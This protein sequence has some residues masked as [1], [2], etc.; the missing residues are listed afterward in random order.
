MS[1]IKKTLEVNKVKK[2]FMLVIMLT[3]AIVAAACGSTAPVETAKTPAASAPAPAA[4]A[5]A[6][7]TPAPA[8]P[9]AP[10]EITIKHQLGETKVKSNAKNL[11]VF[12][13]GALDT[14]DKLGIE[15]TGVAQSSVPTYLAKY[16]DAKYKNIGTLQE[17][18]FEKISAMKP[19]L[20]LIS[21]RQQAHYAELSK[22]APTVFVG[23]D[24]KRY[25]ESFAENVKVIAKIYGKEA[26]ADAELAKITENV[27]KVN[28]KAAASNKK[29]LI[30]LVTGGK[31][32]AYGPGSR[33]GFIHDVLGVVPSEKNIEVSTHGQTIS[34]EYIVEKNPDIL[35]VVD[36]ETA[37]GESKTTA[38]QVIENELV[39]KT[40]AFKNGSIVYL[41]PNY[42]Y[43]SGGGLISVAGMVDEVD[44]GLK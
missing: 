40:N 26:A 1:P 19:E 25:M 4:S 37:V 15:V 22:I 10:T 38:K 17:P 32:S 6:A 34:F 30:T 3:L 44:K 5:P 9:A 35:F 33:F 36:R 31:A 28:A 8:T 42:W 24:N 23:V 2:I 18:D 39:M 13:F 14:L 21:G 7:S 16:K 12:D 29:G 11:V 27:K 20:I 41:D 43:V